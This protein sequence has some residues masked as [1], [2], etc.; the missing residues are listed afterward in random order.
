[1]EVKNWGQIGYGIHLTPFS[2]ILSIKWLFWNAVFLDFF[3]HI[4]I[5][6][7]FSHVPA[8]KINPIFEKCKVDMEILFVGPC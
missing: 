2:C 8:N 4:P 5:I 3:G 1:M 7:K 6:L